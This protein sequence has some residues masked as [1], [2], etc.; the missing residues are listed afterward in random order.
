MTTYNYAVKSTEGYLMLNGKFGFTK[1]M[2][3]PLT[4][5]GQKN[6]HKFGDYY[7]AE[8]FCIETFG[9]DEFE[10]NMEIVKL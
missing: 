9:A 8:T 5:I 10:H 3:H 4:Q 2:F 7:W 6:L 1:D